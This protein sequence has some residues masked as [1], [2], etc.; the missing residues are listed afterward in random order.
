MHASVGDGAQGRGV[1]VEA[2]NILA[3]G[4]EQLP[5]MAGA[6]TPSSAHRGFAVPDAEQLDRARARRVPG[7]GR[8]TSC[9]S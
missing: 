2:V 6:S 7:H 4:D 1:A 3:G 9:S 8:A 5:A